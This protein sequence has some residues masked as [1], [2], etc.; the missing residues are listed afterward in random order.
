MTEEPIDLF[1]TIKKPELP[2]V[3]KVL[4]TIKEYREV[5]DSYKLQENEE[6]GNP[7]EFVKWNQ[8]HLA[9]TLSNGFKDETSDYPIK[10][11]Q[12]ILDNGIPE[13]KW[14]VQDIFT[15]NGVS[16]IGGASGSYKTWIGMYLALCIATGK[17][18]LE[19][20]E[21]QKENVLY[22]DEENGLVTMANRFNMLKYG[23]SFAADK[24]DNLFISVF[25]NVKLDNDEKIKILRT[26]IVNHKIK[27]VILDSMVRCMEGEEDKSKDVR[28]IFDN[29]KPIFKELDVTFIILHHT[30]KNAKKGDID[31]LRGSGDFQGQ[32]DTVMMIHANN[33][34]ANVYLPKVRHLD[35]DSVHNFSILIENGIENKTVKLKWIEGVEEN[36]NSIE[37][38]SECLQDW[39]DKDQIVEFRTEEA[40]KEAKS[41]GFRKNSLYDALK[42][43]INNNEI[44]KLKRGFYKVKTP[45][46]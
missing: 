25:N 45:R 4:K 2:V 27:V 35:R 24:F 28:I 11:L 34:F 12:T 36:K 3:K 29:L 15:R 16:I 9:E 33:N 30:T 19:K 23:N 1:D 5:N 17:P 31:S 43:L 42:L 22:V 7:D 44:C 10:S 46:I 41:R 21:T 18:F 39:I 32:M 6:W 13:I 38:C 40:L 37:A 8:K 14:I 26:I 20:Y